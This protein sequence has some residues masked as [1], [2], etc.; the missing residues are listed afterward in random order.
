MICEII[1]NLT[2][3]SDIDILIDLHRPDTDSANVT[4]YGER[5]IATSIAMSIL[6]YIVTSMLIFIAVSMVISVVIE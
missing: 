2:V 4:V 1:A 6:R 5:S 3:K